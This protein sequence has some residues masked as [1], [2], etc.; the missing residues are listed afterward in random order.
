MRTER[1]LHYIA[2]A[3]YKAIWPIFVKFNLCSQ[4]PYHE[5]EV[6]NVMWNVTEMLSRW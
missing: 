2:A 5:N 3:E 4:F 1:N 6:E